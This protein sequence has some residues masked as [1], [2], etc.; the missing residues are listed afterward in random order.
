[1]SLV[2]VGQVGRVGPVGQVRQVRQVRQVG[3]VG[4]VRQVRL[5]RPVR[6]TSLPRDVSSLSARNKTLNAR[7]HIFLFNFVEEYP[8]AVDAMNFK[9]VKTFQKTPAFS[10]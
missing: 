7:F 1:M 8:K 6:L 3:Q 9:K 4:Q 10:L 2:F 5:V